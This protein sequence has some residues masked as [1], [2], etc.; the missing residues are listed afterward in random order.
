MPVTLAQAK[1]NATDDIDTQV[2][3]EFQKNSFLLDNMTFDD[4]VNQAG[5]GST[6]TY[7]YTRL[8]TQADAAFRAVNTEYVPGEV[9]KQRYTTDLKPLGGSFQIDRILDGVAA[10]AET[11]LQLQQKIK[12][13]RAKFADAVINGDTAV[14]T[15]GFDGLSKILTGSSTEYLPLTNGVATGYLDWTTVNDKATALTA[16]AHID[17]W[18]ATMD[19]EPGAIFG[20][21]KTLALFKRLAIWADQYDKTQDAFGR[22]VN[23]YNNIPLIDLGAKAGS[24]TDVVGLVTRDPDAGGAGGNVTNLGDLFAVRFGLDGFHGVSV[25]GRPLVNWWLPDFTTSGAVKTGEVELGPAAVVLKA[26]K[27]GAVL[28]NIKSA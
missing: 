23:R 2:I 19:G 21:K 28:R 20:N 18:L 15:N 12:A 24:N 14:D 26:T 3:D 4:V 11:T 16:L 25:A 27:S 8:I 5:S 13:T 7:G 1:L 10:A 6:L 17:A 9:T 22:P